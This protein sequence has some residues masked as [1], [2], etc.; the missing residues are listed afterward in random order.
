[1]G[2]K[3]SHFSAFTLEQNWGEFLPEKLQHSLNIA[4]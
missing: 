4:H 3:H 1:M 2:L